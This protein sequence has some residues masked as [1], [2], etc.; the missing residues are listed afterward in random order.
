MIFMGREITRIEGKYQAVKGYEKCPV[1][2]V[3][4]Y[5]AIQYAKWVGKRLPTEAEWERACKDN[6]DLSND[7]TKMGKYAWFKLNSEI[8]THPIGTKEPNAYGLYDMFGNAAEWC[9][10][11]Y[12]EEYYASVLGT[13]NASAKL[14]PQ[15]PDKGKFK[16]NKGG[17][18]L[19]RAKNLR[20]SFRQFKDPGDLNMDI[21]FRCVK[22]VK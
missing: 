12:D 18:Y 8:S 11:W 7:E 20:S 13:S 21:G 2:G 1:T 3:T 16:V 6:K 15:G 17:S 14:N 10:D 22:S 5:G 9:N 4:W 19:Y